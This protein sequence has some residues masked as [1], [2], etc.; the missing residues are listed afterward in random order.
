MGLPRANILRLKEG[1]S[2]NTWNGLD[3]SLPGQLGYGGHGVR[4][5]LYCEVV[6]RHP[7]RMEGNSRT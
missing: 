3:G 2:S 6:G 4:L 7:V 1:G 5:Q